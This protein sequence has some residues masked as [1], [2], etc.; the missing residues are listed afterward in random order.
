MMRVLDGL[1]RAGEPRMAGLW[2]Q[3]FYRWQWR[4]L[5]HQVPPSFVAVATIRRN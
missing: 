5:T 3:L 1:C 2:A 4:Q